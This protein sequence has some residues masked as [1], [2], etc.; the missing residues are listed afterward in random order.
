MK[1]AQNEYANALTAFTSIALC[2]TKTEQLETDVRALSARLL[3]LE[4]KFAGVI[5]ESVH[6]PS[7]SSYHWFT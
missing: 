1:S 3:N 5:S 7:L 4:E 2:T 6:S